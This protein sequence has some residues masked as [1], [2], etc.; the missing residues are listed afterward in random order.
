MTVQTTPEHGKNDSVGRQLLK[1][2]LELG[3]LVVFFLT[4]SSA[5]IFT[6]TK[7]FMVATVI[8]LVASRLVF[9]RVAV[10]PLVTAVFVIVFG[11]LTIW[12]EDEL[13]IKMKPTIVNSLFALIL[14]GGLAFGQSL[15]RYVFGEVF[16]L[17]E[18][19]W[20]QLT[21]RWGGFFVLLAILNEV[22]WRNFSTDTWVAFKTFGI[23]PLTMIFAMAQLGIIKKHDLSGGSSESS[24]KSIE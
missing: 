13:F 23:M 19:G 9:G 5:G 22:M 21:L 4:N 11:G 12:L 2:A 8:S 7:A 15:L 17:T 6:A 16:N 20:R 18:E 1:L 14:L 10:M 3:P 24:G